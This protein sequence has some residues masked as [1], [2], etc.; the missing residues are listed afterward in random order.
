M[1]DFLL[2]LF[3]MANASDEQDPIAD[4]EYVSWCVANLRD[5]S[6]WSTQTEALLS[7]PRWIKIGVE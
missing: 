7:I 4:A 5:V 3:E 2:K 1:D 6:I